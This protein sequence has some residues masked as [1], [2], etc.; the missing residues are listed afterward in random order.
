MV[1]IP[2]FEFGFN[3]IHIGE[4]PI[5]IFYFSVNLQM[6]ATTINV[7]VIISKKIDLV[8]TIIEIETVLR[9]WNYVQSAILFKPS[10]CKTNHSGSIEACNFSFFGFNID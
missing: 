7:G 3:V 5:I 1:V 4:I 8:L 9:F 2:K 10:S 6:T